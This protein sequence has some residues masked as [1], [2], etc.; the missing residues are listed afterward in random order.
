MFNLFIN[1]ENYL[2]QREYVLIRLGHVTFKGQEKNQ[3]NQEEN[4]VMQRRMIHKVTQKRNHKYLT[5]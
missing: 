3:K 5:P 4:T 1:I 2:G